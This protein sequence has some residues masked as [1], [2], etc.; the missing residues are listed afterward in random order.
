[1][2][3]PNISR[4]SPIPYL[5]RAISSLTHPKEWLLLAV[6]GGTKSN[7]SVNTSSVLGLSA[8]MQ[9]V[10]Q[11]SETIASLPIGFFKLD[12]EDNST[13]QRSHPLDR[14]MRFPGSHLT[15]YHFRVTMTAIAILRGNAYALIMRNEKSQRPESFHILVPGMVEPYKSKNELFYKVWGI[16]DIPYTE[17]LHIRGPG[18]IAQ[19]MNDNT[20][21]GLMG[22]DMTHIG[23]ESFG[24]AIAAQDYEASVMG[25]GGNI[26]GF[27][28][29][30]HK[31]KQEGIEDVEERFVDKFYG[32]NNSGGVMVLGGGMEFERVAMTPQE[33]MLLESRKFSIEEISRWLN[34]PLYK[35]NHLDK[36]TFN[37]VEQMNRDY[38]QQT[39]L[40]WGTNWE[41]E[42][43]FKLLRE[44]EKDDHTYK[45]D[46]SQ[47]LRADT[48]AL[49]ELIGT[50][51]NVGIISIDD[52]RKMLG[53]NAKGEEWSKKHWV[54]LN[55]AP[56]DERPQMVEMT[57]KEREAFF[58]L[59]QNNKPSKNGKGTQ[60]LN[61]A[62][63]QDS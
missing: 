21:L 55:L 12:D 43:N 17:I 51:F 31:L 9:G 36:A 2:R 50:I 41:G 23:R 19:V 11:I 22:E 20:E 3:F 24:V 54:Q 58:S 34:M 52:G 15:S 53:L 42:L 18:I 63:V 60:E 49:G 45:F 33:S 39:V 1:M 35:L 56:A 37:N 40:P 5:K 25:K 26:A 14:L 61:G 27:L 59:G 13:R 62:S 38:Y 4:L 8:V 57:K 44:T 6:G 7:V 30:P 10:R 48:E 16:G 29:F 28:K 32:S 47:L 46:Y